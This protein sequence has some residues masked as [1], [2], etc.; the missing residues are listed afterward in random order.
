MSYLVRLD[1]ACPNMNYENWNQIISLL[2]KYNIKALIAAIPENLDTSFHSSIIENYDEILF[3]WNLKHEIAIHGYNHLYDSCS[4]PIYGVKKFSEFAGKD[5]ISQRNLI[6][7]GLEI[8]SKINIFPKFFVA[9]GHSFDSITLDVIRENFPHMIISDGFFSKPVIFNGVKY[10]PQ[11]LANCINIPFS[12]IT[13]CYHPNTMN[14]K[15]F[16]NFENFL[17]KN[18]TKF[19]DIDDLKFRECSY[20]DLIL[21]KTFNV[22]KKYIF[23]VRNISF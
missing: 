16:I 20:F 17:K 18:H 8:F 14:K 5:F 23:Y 19:M 9:P 13:F 4:K 11:Q 22:I 3:D 7:K 21:D 15:D 1:D 6:L 10:L 2:N 12:T